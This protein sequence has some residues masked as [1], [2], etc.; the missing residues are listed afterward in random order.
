MDINNINTFLIDGDG[1]LWYGQKPAEGLVHFFKVLQA[2]GIQWAL[3]TNN[4]TDIV[5]GYA[6]KLAGFGVTVTTDQVFTGA[7]ATA[8][9]LN[10][11]YAPGS[12]VY[13]VGEEG[14][15]T[16]LREAGFTVYHGP[17]MP[18][19]P[20]AAVIG[21]MDRGL[22][23]AKLDV[24]TRLIRSGAPYIGTNPDRTYPTPTGLAPGAGTIVE[25]IAI[26]SATEP[27]IIGK[28]Q[29]AIFEMAMKALGADRAHTAMIGDRLETD[30]AGAKAADVGTILLM[31]GV[32]TPEQLAKCDIQ[33]DCTYE[34]LIELT[35]ALET[36]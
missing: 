8:A 18:E 5:D 27:I 10:E 7:T 23:Y 11:H 16:T 1:V 20:V 6:D 25:A 33:P 13:V 21:S 24:A 15:L 3:L 34:N 30:I 32:T 28:P 19:E 9:Y 14:L 12:A 36:N 29:A 26:A 22:T 35:D 17:E 31:S 2:R 4:A